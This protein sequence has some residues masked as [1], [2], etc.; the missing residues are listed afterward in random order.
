MSRRDSRSSMPSRQNDAL[1]EFESFKR[2][3]LQVNKHIVKINSQLQVKIEELNDKIAQLTTENLTIRATAIALTQQLAKE[4]DKNRHSVDKSAIAAADNAAAFMIQQLETLRQSFNRVTH[5][6]SPGSSPHSGPSTPTPMA[7]KVAPIQRP[8]PSVSTRPNLIAKAPDFSLIQ[9]GDSEEEEAEAERVLDQ[10]TKAAGDIHHNE[11]LKPTTPKALKRKPSRRQSGLLAPVTV[12]SPTPEDLAPPQDSDSEN[13]AAEDEVDEILSRGKKSSKRRTSSK[14]NI[15]LVDVTNSPPLRSTGAANVK[16]NIMSVLAEE[17]SA[18]TVAM[19][20]LKQ[21]RS[22]ATKQ[23][24]PQP[25]VVDTLSPLNPEPSAVPGSSRHSRSSMDIDPVPVTEGRSTRTRKSVNYAEPKL[26]IK[27]R[28]PDEPLAAPYAQ[29]SLTVLNDFFPS[30]NKRQSTASSAHSTPRLRR[31]SNSPDPYQPD[32]YDAEQPKDEESA[33]GVPDQQ[34]RE[35]Q[36]HH[37]QRRRS[38]P[39]SATTGLITTTASPV[40]PSSDEE[41]KD[42]V[43]EDEIVVPSPVHRSPVRRKTRSSHPPTSSKATSSSGSMT[44]EATSSTHPK[45]ISA[46]LKPS[47]SAPPFSADSV[48]EVTDSGSDSIAVR[49]F[50]TPGAGSGVERTLERKP[51]LVPGPSSTSSSTSRK[52]KAAPTRYS[53]MDIDSDDDVVDRED[54]GDYNPK[55]RRKSGSTSSGVAGGTKQKL[56]SGTGSV[57]TSSYKRVGTSS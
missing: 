40:M 26:N 9:E 25:V 53:Y 19:Q 46:P 52:R 56:A 31:E 29:P 23:K 7:V 14:V 8:R 42:N 54:D 37:T 12:R 13:D 24:A 28:K 48:T 34:P 44:L 55:E 38:K 49:S 18:V 32:H 27:M 50:N 57:V 41:M 21:E 51:S 2:K 6:T 35:S 43:S 17:E 15:R 20:S 10:Q 5:H 33:S 22:S 45:P 3:Y 39:E 36:S 30:L 11:D 16:K 47:K 4:R 1:Q